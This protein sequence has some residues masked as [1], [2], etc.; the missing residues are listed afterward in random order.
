MKLTKLGE[1]LT[2][3]KVVGTKALFYKITG[4]KNLRTDVMEGEYLAPPVV[5]EGFRIFGEGL[6]GGMRMIY[7]S[8]IERIE[9]TEGGFIIHT[10]TGSSYGIQIDPNQE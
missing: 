6:K 10:V 8:D 2:G 7:T 4:G 5:G 9:P 1:V 3:K